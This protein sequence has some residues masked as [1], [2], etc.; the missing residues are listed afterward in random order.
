MLLGSSTA[1][2]TAISG[3]RDGRFGGWEDGVLALGLDAGVL[4]GALITPHLDWSP[5]RSKTVL[6]STAVGALLGGMLVG[7]ITKRS[8]GNTSSGDLVAGCMTAGRRG[9][10]WPGGLHDK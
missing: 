6:A 5:R 2:F 4:G 1:A 7:M 8:N 3:S 10:F 9:Q